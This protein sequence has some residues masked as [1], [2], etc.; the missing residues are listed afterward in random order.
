MKI[1]KK[2]RKRRA[3]LPPFDSIFGADES[4]TAVKA[5]L[6]AL[7]DPRIERHKK[8]RLSDIVVMALC[9]MICG[10]EG[11]VPVEQFCLRRQSWFETVLALKHG[12]PSHDTFG[13]VFSALDPDAF[14]AALLALVEALVEPR[15][16][17]DATGNHVAVDGKT[18]RKSFDRAAKQS[19]LH[20]ISVWATATQTVIG[21]IRTAKK[22]NEIVELPKLLARLDLRGRTVTLDAMGCQKAIAETITQ[23]KGDYVFTLKANHKG[24][25]REVEERFRYADKRLAQGQT[26]DVW[27]EPF[28]HDTDTTIDGDH[29]RIEQRTIDALHA[30]HWLHS[31]QPGWPSIQSVIRINATR[32][33]GDKTTTQVRYFISSLPQTNAA[34]LGATIR[35]HWAIENTLHWTLDTAFRED[36]CRIRKDNAPQNAATLRRVAISLLKNNTAVKAGIKTKRM[37]AAADLNYLMNILRI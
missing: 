3:L 32:S 37:C 4:F 6:S 18:L 11:W 26:H 33:L 15:S 34:S 1:T 25:R 16:G 29:G 24:L 21:Q 20:L 2:A 9:A 27:D 36:D 23:Q 13:R 17:D 10:A 22:T 30:G 5:Q 31:R 12:I 35:A 14:S 7:V 8:H 28:S 19:A